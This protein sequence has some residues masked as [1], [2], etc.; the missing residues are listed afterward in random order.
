MTGPTGDGVTMDYI[1]VI[2]NA[3][4]GWNAD[5]GTT[6]TG[7]LTVTHYNISWNGCAEQYPTTAALPY[8]DC[9]DD[10]AGGYGDGFGTASMP[11]SPAWNISFDQGTVSYNTQDGLDALHLTGS[12]STMSVSRT[13]AFS[14]MGQ[15]IKIG[16]ASSSVINNIITT[17]CNAMR[18]AI[19]GTPSGYNARLS[20]FCRA[21]DS[22]MV[23]MVGH[24][25]NLTMQQNTIYSASATGVEIDCDTTYGAC[26]TT[27]TVDIE[28]NIFLGFIN[29]SATGYVG[30]GTGD[31]SNYIYNGS[32][33]PFLT[34]RGS[35]FNRNITYHAKSSWA[36]PAQGES[37]AL[38]QDPGLASESW[39]MY[40]SSSGVLSLN[41]IAMHAGASLPAIKLDIV[42]TTR[43]APPT[44]GAIELP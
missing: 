20:D 21:A 34:N 18:Q 1:D 8:Q 11:S 25:S 30:G 44:I 36:C 3:A 2:G 14:N 16:G 6:G 5:D 31:Y 37:G 13:Y 9:T 12:G 35:I 27:S 19:P 29:N 43:G 15:Q 39:P 32:G 42:G 33:T 17:N 40:G 23:A 26:D 24:S 7:K 22:G 38:C 28:N 41:S 4:A 10:N